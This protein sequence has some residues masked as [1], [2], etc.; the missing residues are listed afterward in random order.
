[1]PD[2]ARTLLPAAWDVPVLRSTRE[3]VD[4]SEYAGGGHRYLCFT[5]HQ[6]EITTN[7]KSI[8]WR[9]PDGTWSSNQLGSGIGSLLKHLMNT[10]FLDQLEEQEEQGQRLLRDQ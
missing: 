7:D 6:S 8:L 5:H 4:G 3:V 10:I 2:T 9:Q 1:M